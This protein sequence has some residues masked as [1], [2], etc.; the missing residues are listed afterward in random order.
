[1]KSFTRLFILVKPDTWYISFLYFELLYSLRPFIIT[2]ATYNN[3]CF[4]VYKI[5]KRKTC[6]YLTLSAFHQ[7]HQLDHGIKVQL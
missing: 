5:N 4:A 2:A 6:H 3:E 7:G 1:M